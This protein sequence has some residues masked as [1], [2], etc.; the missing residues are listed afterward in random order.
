MA[1]L[2]GMQIDHSANELAAGQQYIMT[3]QDSSVLDYDDQDEEAGGTEILENVDLQQS[4][5][6]R[7][8]NKR[9]DKLS[10][11]ANSK[12]LPLQDLADEDDEVDAWNDPS[13]TLASGQHLLSKYDDVAEMAAN[14]K[15]ANRIQIG[16]QGS[17]SVGKL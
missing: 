14:K 2:K 10:R 5:R 12:M 11:H 4:F 7:I 16:S 1:E 9:K 3:L 15:R 8:A 17:A 6:Q 13:E